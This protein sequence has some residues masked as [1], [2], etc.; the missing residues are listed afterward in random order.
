LTGTRA[1]VIGAGEMA[2]RVARNL[3]ADGACA[4]TVANRTLASANAL[5]DEIG[6]RAIQFDQLSSALVEADLVISATAAPH[7]ILDTPT[8]NAVMQARNTRSL[9]LI[10]IA[11]PRDIDPQ[12]AGIPQVRLFNI[13]DLNRLVDANRAEREKAV[14]QVHAI[15]A[16]E[17]EKFWEWYV[18]RRAAPVIS[19][20]RG[21][22]ESIREAELQKAFRRLGHL[23]LTDRDRNVI[24]ALS[25]GI[26]GKLLAAPTVNLKERVQNGDGQVYL[27][28]LR[29][30]FELGD[31][32]GRG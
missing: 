17:V 15:I 25:A 19:K 6:G 28:T 16:E 7:I 22:A 27:D 13:D 18:E 32:I 21:R 9:C 30:L 24:A 31:H 10:D 8:V 4:V 12:V 20:L 26:V 14:T 3:A 5:A 2:E 1:L 29:E 11:V 23:H